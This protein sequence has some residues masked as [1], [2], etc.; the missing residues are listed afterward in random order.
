M[1]IKK[2]IIFYLYIYIQNIRVEIENRAKS[3]TRTHGQYEGQVF[4]S[5]IYG[6]QTNTVLVF[7]RNRKTVPQMN[8]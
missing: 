2:I 5:A 8:S 7:L 1:K 6:L 3:H 4:R